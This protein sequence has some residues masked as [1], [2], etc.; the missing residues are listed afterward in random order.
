[1]SPSEPALPRGRIKSTPEDFVVEELPLYE[2]SGEGEHLYIRFTKRGLTTD[3]AVRSIA[4][5]LRLGASARDVGV[6][7][8]KDKVAI[9]TQTISVPIP[10]QERADKAIDERA[11]ALT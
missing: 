8:M 9:T 10:P 3:A 4:S 6:A 2:P 1:M 7:G 11:R 5:A